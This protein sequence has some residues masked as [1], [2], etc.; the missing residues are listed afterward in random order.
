MG[1]T[2]PPEATPPK[3]TS[4]ASTSTNVA[5]AIAN[6]YLGN[7]ETETTPYGTTRVTQTGMESIY[8]PYTEANY[9]VP[10]FSRETVLSPEQQAITD[11]L[12]ASSLNM[13]SMANQASA[14]LE[15]HLGTDFSLDNA[16]QSAD[17][18]D[19]YRPTYASFDRDAPAYVNTFED[20]GPIARDI[21]GAGDITRTYGTDHA[22]ER[23]RVEDAMTERLEPQMVR[24]RERL[25]TRL[26]NMGIKINNPAYKEAMDEL[27]RKQNDARLG[28]IAAG[29]T[30]L[31]R[32]TGIERDRAGFENTAQQQLFGQNAA[33]AAFG[34]QAQAQAFAQGSQE[35]GFFNAAEQGNFDN[36]MR[37]NAA[38]NEL[39]D[40]IRA[41]TVGDFQAMNDLRSRYMTEQFAARNQPINEISALM[42]GS[43]VQ[44]PV[45]MGANMPTIPTTDNAG[46]IAN[47]DQ[48]RA[49][50]WQMEQQMSSRLL[51]GL[52]GFGSN[53]IAS[54]R[55]MKENVEK[56]GKTND[57]QPLY[58]YNYK[59]DPEKQQQIGLMAQDVKK[60][61]PKAVV[62]L[63]NGLM[64]VDYD[65]ALKDA[66]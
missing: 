11:E 33:E 36:W 46:I 25:H 31:S 24:D 55:R 12:N 43:Q 4:E 21:D 10:R 9:D 18:S 49:N 47:Y 2:S 56:V 8:D 19:L 5:T 14:N 34:N 42:S 59:G 16:P 22:T 38:N 23:R 62:T 58:S 65:K 63:G 64:M 54:D 32:M 26:S 15:T 52:L 1:K 28:V 29:G 53:L 13:A 40:K 35:A 7:L 39:Q 17:V 3:E 30:E 48:Q 27:N 44:Q 57:G 41:A 66:G 50:N 60:K 20:A 51:G 45:F 37:S 61:K 6:A